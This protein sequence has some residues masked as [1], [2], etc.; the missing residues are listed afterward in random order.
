MAINC[1]R[2]YKYQL[3]SLPDISAMTITDPALELR[4]TDIKEKIAAWLQTRVQNHS[5]LP[6][7]RMMLLW[8]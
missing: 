7:G 6:S 5:L 3:I 8:T 4:H 2:S 1:F